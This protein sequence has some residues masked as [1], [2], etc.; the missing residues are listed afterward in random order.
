MATVKTGK[1]S[2]T[3]ICAPPYNLETYGYGRETKYEWNEIGKIAKITYADNT[4]I[5]YEYD[6]LGNLTKITDALG[7]SWAGEYDGAGRLKREQGRPGIDREYR[8]DLLGRIIEV[9]SGGDVVEQYRYTERGRKVIF[10]DGQGNNFAQQKN[11]YGELAGETN[12]LNDRQSY[13]Y[14]A[15]GRLIAATAYSGKQTREKKRSAR[16]V[17]SN[18]V[19]MANFSCGSN[20]ARIPRLRRERARA[21][22]PVHS[23]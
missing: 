2:K 3:R 22:F 4:S 6:H 8:Y 10:T 9:K 20:C 17:L 1:R 12:R 11:A 15:E 14:D 23:I 5:D 18:S 7:I 13:A 16:G 19:A 21:W